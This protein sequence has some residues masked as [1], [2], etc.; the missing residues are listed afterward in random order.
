MSLIFNGHID[1]DPVFV[2][3]DDPYNPRIEDRRLIGHGL[4]NMK[5]AVAA[6]VY[7][8]RAIKKA[9]VELKGDLIVEPVV[10]EIQGGIGTYYNTFKKN[11]MADYGL[12][13][14]PTME[15]L[16]TLHAG[17]LEVAIT[18]KG[19]SQHISRMG[20]GSVDA[21]DKTIKVIEA[22]KR[23]KFP[24]KPDPRIPGLPRFVIGALKCGH[25]DDQDLRGAAFIIDNCTM[26][27][28]IRYLPGMQPWEDIRKVLEDLK[29][30]DPEFKYELKLNPE[31]PFERARA[32]KLFVNN[33]YN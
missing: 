3:C 31:D 27:V 16:R 8:A 2:G 30:E 12:V 11:I 9:G 6:M 32:S 17:A 28:D 4:W 5:A 22:L 1:T 13:P 26:I 23:M 7:A 19:T 24:Y 33:A 14:E 29:A 21:L 10:G 25:G 20:W 15:N 18:V